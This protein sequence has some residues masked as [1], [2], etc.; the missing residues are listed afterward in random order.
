M[1]RKQLLLLLLVVVMMAFIA[2]CGG[3]QPETVTV[4][5]TVVVEKEVVKE[6]EVPKEVT[7][8]VEVEK[9]VV[10]E[11]E[12][13]VTTRG[14]GGTLN[15]LYWQAPSTLNSHLASGTKDY[16]A[17]SVVL[18]PQANYDEGGN[19]VPVLA[20][21]IPTLE[22]GGIAEDLMSIT[23]KLKEGVV[24]SDG[25]PFTA[26][27][28]IFTW[29]YC[30][31]E[32]AGCSNVTSFDGVKSVEA[33][34]DLTVTIT[35]DAPTAFPYNPFVS[36]LAM[37]L[38]KAQFEECVGA[39]AQGCSE[40]NSAPIGT[41]PYKVKEFKANDVVTYEVNENFRDPTKPF[42][43]EV[44]F[45]GGGD[46]ASAARAALETGEVDYAWN[47]QVEPQ[48]LNAMAAAGKGKLVTAF[49][50]NLER[51]LVNFTNPDP[52]LGDKRSEWSEEDPNPHPF[53]SDPVVRQALSMAIDRS[54][55]AT[56]L[57]GA[58][59]KP[60]CNIVT[61]PA[62]VVSTAN[63]AC[64]IQDIAGANQMLDEAGIVDSDGDGVREKDGV[65]LRILYQTS[66]NPV[67]QKTQALVKQ[68]WSE[69]GVETEL[70]DVDAA[71]YF[72]GDVASP[73]TYNK[74]YADV[75]MYT[76]GP[77]STDP[78]SYLAGWL[79]KNSDGSLNIANAGNQWLGNN[80]DR[81]C[82]EEYD[83]LF[84][85]FQ[86]TAEP[87]ERAELAKQLSDMLVQNYVEIPLV[88]RGSVSAHANSLLGVRLGG[89]DSE[90]WNIED[91]TRSS[92]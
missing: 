18:E 55:I 37:I 49:A 60:S 27:D 56:Q 48:I 23:W 38:Q 33:P 29:E 20:A 6:V 42:F 62:A 45:K 5:E 91:W 81:W 9:E 66:T 7:K 32:E 28:V 47:L 61:G 21:E 2:A 14:T 63:D 36:S 80:I 15:I 58:A 73:D 11:V 50:G 19:L 39:K 25:T 72:G 77:S 83:A 34:D 70:K 71:V 40:Q 69:I 51:I 17:A 13:L 16:D 86:G 44:V 59:G 4:V 68:W 43:S 78:Q 75:E 30:V 87:A 82:N 67:R 22:N 85:E 12:K 52:A 53:L 76:N 79:C 64:L 1:N 24:W 92:Q 31:N 10:K 84:Q 88:Y 57:Y 90:M 46:A 26:E 65:P 74:F 3:A 89:W 8:V 41:G 35:F 54:T